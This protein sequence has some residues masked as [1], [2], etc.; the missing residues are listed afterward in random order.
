MACAGVTLAAAG[1]SVAQERTALLEEVVVTAERRQESLQDVPLSITAFGSEARDKIGILSIQDMANFAP[2][3]TY[4]TSQ[5]RPSI[6]GIGRQS[7]FF[8]MDSPVANYF[9]GVYTTSV[10]DAQR[11]PIFI[12]RTEIL[13]GPQGA[14]SGRN[15]IGGVV[16]TISKMPRDEFGGEARTYY[17]DYE[18]YGVEGTVTGPITD[19]ARFR[20]NGGKY[21]QDE[22]YFENVAL[23][24]DEG[25]QPNNRDI[26]DILIDA[27]LGESVELF[28]KAAWADYDES[29]RTLVSLAP[30]VSGAQNAPNPFG[31]S[32]SAFTPP[33]SWG[34][35]AG[36][37]G[38]VL[39]GMNQ[40]PVLVT[41]DE[42]KFA[43]DYASRQKLDNH[44]NY[45]AQ[46]TWHAPGVDVK[47]IGGHQ[48]YH[49]AQWQDQDGTD[50]I[51]MTLPGGRRV[52]P[53]GVN[54]YAEDREWYSNELTLTSTS[55]GPFRWILGLYQ[56][57][58][59]YYQEPATLTFPGYP[60]L[61]APIYGPT[62]LAP[63][64]PV[65][66]RAQYGFLDGE[67]V[68]RAAFGQ[69]DYE[70]NDQWK[71]TFGL[72]YNEDEK[73]ADEATR[74]IGNNFGLGLAAVGVALDVTP[75]PVPG[76][77][78]Q[79]GVVRDN[80]VDPATG[81]RTRVLNGKWSATTGSVGI[82]FT[83]TDDDLI[84]LRMARGYRPGGF[85]SGGFIDNTAPTRVDKETVNSYEVGYKSTF[86]DRLQ[87]S[88]SV[89]Y[90]DY[91]D[92]QLSLPS[93]GRCS[94]PSDL[95]TCTTIASF[96]NVAA[97]ETKGFELETNWAITEQLNAY[98]TYGYLDATIEDGLGQAGTGFINPDD[99]AAVR[100]NANRHRQ[101]PGQVDTGFTFLPVYTQNLSGNTLANSPEHRVGLNMNYTIPFSSGNL[102]LSGSYV[103]RD[104]QYSNVF[105]MEEFKVPSWST[106][107]ARIAWTDAEDRYTIMLYGSNLTNE[108]A[109]DAALPVPA[110]D[111]MPSRQPTGLATAGAPSAAGVAYYNRLNLLP[112]RE[113]GLEL[114]YRF[115]DR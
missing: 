114:Q 100:Q 22:G 52:N 53:G 85:S 54:M 102:V 13:R 99:R 49:Y 29:R 70:F 84:F 9:D 66:F 107:G 87:V 77:P 95:S 19:W 92:I 46:L 71:V 35:F 41:G 34:Y 47:W 45:T 50:V 21:R 10:Q 63:A 104:E 16:N 6:R 7:N 80:G 78:L 5:D 93:L 110:A 79:P 81:Y 25:D 103:W 43:A 39:S 113:W 12:E 48:N 42:R 15:S 11:R 8:T 61:N 72:R 17:G 91:E 36:S 60:E 65:P 57:N 14:L 96:L 112:P 2:G 111:P 23:N 30:Y 69:V 33:A 101:V 3:V 58:E 106:V 59:D 97:G 32:G 37:G 115:G 56:S 86:A 68:S 28:L 40:N 105:E 20:I 98:L 27:D 26:I 55:E 24:S 109:A 73:D 67:T 44:H 74:Y 82:D 64:N 76:A 62:T 18:R 51:A 89:F 1:L 90:Y 31:A 108:I 88:A 94:N 83:P 75:Q 38:V 4:D